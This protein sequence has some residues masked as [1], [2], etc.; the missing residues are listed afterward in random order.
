MTTEQEAGHEG[1]ARA[2]SAADDEWKAMA[3]AAVENVA[4]ALPEFCV[5]AIWDS[6]LP[7]PKEA[8]AIGHVM[9][10][11]ARNGIIEK[12]DVFVKSQQVGCHA[13]DRR[14]WRSL[15]CAA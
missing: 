13:T 9:R 4:L 11:A 8:R 7:K 5:D 15:V 2:W 12:T 3:E 6:G 10:T 1:A 14:I